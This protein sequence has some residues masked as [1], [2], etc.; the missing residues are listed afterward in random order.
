MNGGGINDGID[1]GVS[2]SVGEL[3]PV[4]KAWHHLGIW[5]SDAGKVY[6]FGFDG[7]SGQIVVS[8]LAFKLYNGIDHIGQNLLLVVVIVHPKI[9]KCHTVV[10]L[11]FLHQHCERNTTKKVVVE[12]DI[13]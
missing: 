7:Y 5:H 12:L 4:H 13:A 3:L 10:F 1:V 6:L 2:K 11:A 9:E 8:P